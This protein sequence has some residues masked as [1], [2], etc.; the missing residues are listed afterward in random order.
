MQKVGVITLDCEIT[1]TFMFWIDDCGTQSNI[2][3]NCE[4]IE[5]LVAWVQMLSLKSISFNA[6]LCD[7]QTVEEKEV[8][9]PSQPLDLGFPDDDDDANSPEGCT[10]MR[11][12]FLSISIDVFLHQPLKSVS[13]CL[14]FS[15]SRI[16][17]PQTLD[18]FKHFS[19]IAPS[20]CGNLPESQNYQWIKPSPK[21]T[22]SF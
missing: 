7:F 16:L 14:H 8:E 1:H 2:F 13:L 20:L 10:Y 5:M 15:L 22:C 6:I 12:F 18:W 17:H 19:F 11:F 21:T 9:T 4:M 3:T